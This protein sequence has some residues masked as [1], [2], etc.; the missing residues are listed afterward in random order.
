MIHPR[1]LHKVVEYFL[2]ENPALRDCDTSLQIAIIRKKYPSAV[3]VSQLDGMEYV[4]VFALKKFSQDA[5]KR[6]RARIQ[7]EQG[8]YLPND[9]EVRKARKIKQEEYEK[10][11]RDEKINDYCNNQSIEN[12][13]WYKDI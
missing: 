1:N 4:A 8:K 2:R 11:I 7:N 9:P 6:A 13:P 12:E 3:R 10:W 5:I